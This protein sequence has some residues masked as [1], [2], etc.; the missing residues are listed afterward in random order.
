MYDV[1]LATVNAQKSGKGAQKDTTAQLKTALTDARDAYQAL[2]KV[3][4]AT[5]SK[6]EQRNWGW[7]RAARHGG[8]HCGGYMLFDNAGD[9]AALA[10][11]GYDAER[12]A[13]ERAQD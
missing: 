13:A 10:H 11:F 6:E 2:A 8:L 9:I 12:L 3:A 5:L 4:R 1:A 7:Q